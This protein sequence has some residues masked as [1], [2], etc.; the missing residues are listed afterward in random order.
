MHSYLND[1]QR[2]VCQESFLWSSLTELLILIIFYLNTQKQVVQRLRKEVETF[3][4]ENANGAKVSIAS[5]LGL[6]NNNHITNN[7]ESKL[8]TGN[9]FST[10]NSKEDY[11]EIVRNGDVPSPTRNLAPTKW[12]LLLI[13]RF[14]LVIS[15]SW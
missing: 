9:D 12:V 13:I 6:N 3:K 5:L 2:T 14:Q 8:K 10:K 15:W 1:L 4:A 7:N 11:E